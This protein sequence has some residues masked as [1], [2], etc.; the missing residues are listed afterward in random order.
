M[1]VNVTASHVTLLNISVIYYLLSLADGMTEMLQG[2][3]R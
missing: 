3:T 2:N 1:S